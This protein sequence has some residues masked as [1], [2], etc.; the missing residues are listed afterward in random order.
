MEIQKTRYRRKITGNGIKIPIL[1]SALVQRINRRL[2]RENQYSDF[3]PAQLHVARGRYQQVG[4]YYIT[5]T[6]PAKARRASSLADIPTIARRPVGER[7][8]IQRLNRR[9]AKDSQKLCMSR[10]RA[11][12]AEFGK[13]SVADTATGEVT[14]SIIEVEG[15][16]RDLGV[17][18]PWEELED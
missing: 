5:L 7:S 2:A 14:A 17:L 12:E 18:R 4:R 8:L 10:S 11:A 6:A 9:L 15:L 16:A 1:K 13:F 3:L